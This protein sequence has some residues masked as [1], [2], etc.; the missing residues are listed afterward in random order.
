MAGSGAAA[1]APLSPMGGVTS[2]MENSQEAFIQ[3]T[4]SGLGRPIVQ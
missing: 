3:N 4:R 1:S 2:S